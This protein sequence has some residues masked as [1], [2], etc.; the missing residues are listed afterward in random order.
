[1]Q[2]EGI[3]LDE[4]ERLAYQDVQLLRDALLP[5]LQGDLPEGYSVVDR[6]DEIDQRMDEL[7][8][9]SG[10]GEVIDYDVF[11]N[12]FEW[13]RYDDEEGVVADA[14]SIPAFYVVEDG[15]TDQTIQAGAAVAEI[16]EGFKYIWTDENGDNALIHHPQQVRDA[17]VA[18]GD[19]WVN[20]SAL[21]GK[22][23]D[24]G[25]HDKTMVNLHDWRFVYR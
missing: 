11:L 4:H 24:A 25:W 12:A 20:R 16:D 10:N 21:N 15:T 5:Q 2:Y 1:M 22:A 8:D 23:L 3:D 6:Y 7:A 13:P 14:V 9:Q 19:E 17:L 18:F